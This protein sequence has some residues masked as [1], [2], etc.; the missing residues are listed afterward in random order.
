MITF[1]YTDKKFTD[2]IFHTVAIG[3]AYEL[4]RHD[5][6]EQLAEMQKDMHFRYCRCHGLFHEDMAVAIRKPDGTLGFQWH[7]MDKFIDNLLSVGLKP[8]F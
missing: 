5:L 3:R 8:F 4:L 7:H 2:A 6:M 1:E